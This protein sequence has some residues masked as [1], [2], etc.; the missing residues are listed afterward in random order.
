MPNESFTRYEL[1]HEAAFITLDSPKTRNALTATIVAELIAH[2]RRAHADDAVRAIVLTGN[3][4]AFCAGADLRA[5]GNM[6]DATP[7]GGNPFV[8][9]L[10]LMRNGDKPVIAA[11]N[12]AAFGGGAGLVAAADI[13]I[14]VAHASFSFSEVRIGVIPAMISVV[15]LPKL[16]EH[17]TM[18]LF[19]TGEKFSAHEAHGYGL[20]HKVVTADLLDR[21]VLAEIR[22]I[23]AGGPNAIREAKALV[24]NVARLSEDAGY[25][26]A[27]DKIAKLFASAE[28]VEGISAFVEKRPAAWIKQAVKKP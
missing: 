7:S 2:L 9:V 16:G 18:R 23:A 10:K 19:L 3:G 11:V 14:A 27:E 13:A 15:V 25:A 21:T 24:R 6:G 4:S 17:Q 28:A 26:Y 12:G 8:E 1:K 20:L 22:A 5:R